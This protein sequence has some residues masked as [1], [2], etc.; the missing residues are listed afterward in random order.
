MENR[1]ENRAE[2]QA[3]HGSGEDKSAAANAAAE[4]KEGEKKS[5]APKDQVGDMVAKA[6]SPPAFDKQGFIS[7]VLKEVEKIAPETLDDV[8]KFS[9]RGKAARIKGAVKGEV[10][11][12]S[13]ATQGPLQESTSA[14]PGAGESPRT[15]APL[16]VEPPG[17]APGSIRA[18]RAMP[19]PKT[20]S[21]MDL[22]ADTVRAD[23]ILKEACVTREFMEKHDDAELKDGIA[24]QDDLHAVTEQGP[25]TFREGE[26]AQLQNARAGASGA[27]AKGV[28][29]MFGGRS[30]Q[31]GA[32]GT[33]QQRTKTE[34]EVK[35]E[36]AATAINTIFSD[37]QTKVQDRLKQLDKDVNDTFDRET[38]AATDKFE[39]FVRRNAEKYQKSWFDS[40]VDFFS[41]LLFDPPPR[42]VRDFYRE[43]R[44]TFLSD[45]EAVIGN[46][47]DLVETGLNDARD[48][49]AD[50]KTQVQTK[51]DTLGGDL[52]DF[53][54]QISEQMKDKFRKLEGDINAKQGEIVKGLA[55]RYVKAFEKVKAIEN[56]VREEYKNAFE[57]AQDALN[58]AVDFVVGWAEKL[59]TVVGGAAT[60]IIKSPAK[61]L[62]NL[63]AGIVQGLQMF[64]GDIGTNIKAA[65]VEWTTGNMAGG[66]IQ[67]PTTFDAKGII[68]FLLDLVGLGVAGIKEIARQVFGRRVVGLIEKGVA[69]FEK[70]KIIFDILASEGPA[71]LFKFLQSE[72][73]KEGKGDG[74][75]GQGARRGPRH[76]RD[77]ACS[78][79]HLRPGQRRHWIGR[80][81][82]GHHHRPHPL[83]PRQC[84]P[85][86]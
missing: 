15:A 82:R 20:A 72:F 11:Q 49:V 67:L 28:S 24:A 37:T 5:H 38:Q 16:D 41:D 66:G 56:Q 40:A 1:S 51:L 71:G 68:G 33:S 61:F 70:I 44:V 3:A 69:G 23:N 46:V 42:E 32:V 14:D 73:V 54:Q 55:K 81:H 30:G 22:R 25:Q 47:A 26:A 77:Q 48:L 27:G 59:A 45:M 17:P 75:G 63:G 64:I 79:N 84:R 85:D 29:E 9:G 19:P 50:G 78:G 4:V 21:E 35:R 80:H 7:S 74:R 62:R 34:N 8:V 18:D 83:V 76:C 53:K 43:G 39:S 57:K 12:S 10:A 31:F 65:V 2:N 52:A 13:E 6:E 36:A 86:R 60:K 58:A